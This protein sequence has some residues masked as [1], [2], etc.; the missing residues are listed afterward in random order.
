MYRIIQDG[1]V[2]ASST[3][4]NDAVHYATVYAADGPVE[5]QSKKSGKWV[6]AMSMRQW[7]EGDD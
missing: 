3:S 1:M 6:S 7:G 5:V 2:V 4:L